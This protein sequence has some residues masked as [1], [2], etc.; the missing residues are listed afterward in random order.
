M[1]YDDYGESDEFLVKMAMD[2]NPPDK[3]NPKEEVHHK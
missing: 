1:E 2:A 3:E